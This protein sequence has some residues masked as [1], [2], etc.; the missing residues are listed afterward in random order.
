MDGDA[1][2]DLDVDL[3][4]EEED[5]S[6]VSA[7]FLAGADFEQAMTYAAAVRGKIDPTTFME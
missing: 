4:G 1:P 7:L 2:F 5:E 3:G 6:M